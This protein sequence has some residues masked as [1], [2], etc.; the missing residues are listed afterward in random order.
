MTLFSC[1]LLGDETLTMGCGDQL[2]EQG[3]TIRAISTRDSS[4]R[5]WAKARGIAVL[6][7]FDDIR[8]EIAP[9]SID[10]VLSIANLRVIPDAVLAL[11]ARGAVNFHDGPL[12]EY[13]GLNTPVWALLNGEARHGITWHHV[14]AGVDEGDIMLQRRFDLAPD[15]TAH[16]LNARCY[17]AAMDS[18]PEVIRE[19][20]SA[21]PAR[22]PQDLSQR[23][24][25][26]MADLPEMAGL[27]DLRSMTTDRVLRHVRALDF[28]GYA[29]P[30]VT[31]KI[32]SATRRYA[33]RGA[34]PMQGRGA[35]G[36]ILRISGDTLSVATLD[37]AVHLSGI[38]TPDG[39]AAHLSRDLE[40]GEILRTPPAPEADRL[41]T[42]LR[43]S[44]R[45]EGHW[46]A[47][48]AD[49]QPA[50]VP[51]A[52]R[53]TT[54]DWTR[55]RINVDPGLDSG[56]RMAAVALWAL[57]S[58]GQ[59]RAAL[60]ARAQG[61]DDLICD[62][63]PVQAVP[64]ERFEDFT[65]SVAAQ[66]Q[67]GEQHLSFA[68]D[69]FARDPA[70]DAAH[71]PQI[72]VSDTDAPMADTA[73]T[74]CPGTGGEL[75]LHF[76][77]ARLTE[78][79]IGLLSA[80]LAAILTRLAAGTGSLR[81]LREIPAA[82]V[83]L[84]E[85]WNRT[86]TDY[87]ADL[88]LHGAFEAQVA[89]TPDDIALVFEDQ[90]LSYAALNSRANA[91]AQRLIAAGVGPGVNVGLCVRRS[92]DMMVAALG[93]LKAGGA[94]VP[95]DPAYP[96]GRIAHCV[97]DSAAT[98]IV[99]QRALHDLLP[100]S[101]ALL[102]DVEDCD[103]P[104]AQNPDKGV[105][106]DDLAYL[107][108]T[109]GTT[110]L[111]KGVMIAHRNLANFFAGMDA[112]IDRTTGNVWLAV[113]SLAFDISVLELF[114]TLARGFK[115]VIAG[116][117]NRAAVAGAGAGAMARA[118]AGAG[119]AMARSRRDIDFGIYYWGNDGGAGTQKYHL[120]LEGAKFADQNGFNAIWTPERHF[121]AF[122]G[123]YPNPAVTGAAVAAVTQNIGVRA[124]SCV[125][126]LHHPA[127]IA[128]EWA[129]IDN[130]TNGRAGLAI[131][132]GWQPDDFVLRPENAPPDNK[133]AMYDTLAQVRALWRGEAVA[134]P[135]A[136]G[137]THDVITQP[138]PVTP[139][140]PVWITTAGNPD[141][142]REAGELGCNVLTHLL[143]QSI[144]EVAGK[145]RIYHDA[146]RA[147][148]HDPQ[149]FKVTMML[150]TFIAADRD[151]AQRIAREPMKDY[152]RSAAGLIKQY[153]WTFP[154]FKRPEGVK[155]AYEMDLGI[156]G[157]DEL[158]AILDFAFER[159]F[160]E[161]GLFGTVEDGVARAEQLKR[162][163]VDEI[164]CLIDYGIDAQTVLDGLIPLAEVLKRA[165]APVT[166]AADDHSI[167]A[168]IIRHRVTHLQCTPSMARLIAMN[169][170]ARMALS[171]V[172]QILLGGE[173]LPGSLM[174]D[175]REATQA[176]VLNMYG[177]TETTIWSSV[178]SASPC[179]GTVPI[180][181]P[182]AN[183]SL[184]V[185]GADG[186]VS[187]IGVPGE[188]LIGGDG[189][190]PGYWQRADLT[191][192][193]FASGLYRTGDLVAWQADGSLRF[194][195]RSD[196]QVKIR[197]HRIELGEIETCLKGFAGV[198]EAVVIARAARSGD[199]AL[200]AYYT[201][202][203][204]VAEAALRDHLRRALPEVMVPSD[205]VLL[206]SFPLTPNKK[207]DR[208]ALPDPRAMRAPLAAN[209]SAAPAQGAGKVIA[210]VWC[211]IL[212]LPVVQVSDNFFDL[213]GHSLLAVQAHRDIR[214]KLDGVA[215]SITD[216]FRF[217]VLGDLAAHLD[218]QAGVS[219]TVAPRA[220]AP[221]RAA[222]M[223]KR[224][225]M[226][227]GRGTGQ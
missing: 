168:Q 72:G 148:G 179:A 58:S 158:E 33:V 40:I 197:G 188:L 23:R 126:P 37:G 142:W 32:A 224:R 13:A 69:L 103:T 75:G 155:S 108:Y 64:A 136:S 11:P 79:Q 6:P 180:G 73:I 163:G 65:R 217:P 176:Q 222:T 47:A 120:L 134:F 87:D 214:A 200:A 88:T 192:E 220:S 50:E 111:P 185:I 5:A 95:L 154:A 115:V 77:A 150:H 212:G 216:I 99:T 124:G 167:A 178:G 135:T 190:A 201:A 194:I 15:E 196:D 110:G 198:G 67:A 36:S 97:A 38:T 102:I 14:G 60:A 46:R 25:Y 80:R 191:A 119:G 182:I 81:E 161:S 78:A 62:W 166:L 19:L 164:A 105:G 17:G 118:G 114:Y 22:L 8:R 122:G 218:A 149:A 193:R 205:L 9:A 71:R 86:P 204:P 208:L 195:G 24:V 127:R 100:Q 4:V 21:A 159:Y 84:I 187:P 116:D 27:M 210:A 213:G 145:I 132:S 12:P 1:I 152:L 85:G 35:A 74:V 202:T 170:E 215:L 203:A 157:E 165:K 39:R 44:A 146:L 66:V 91:M 156:L 139:E 175:L 10:W 76:D 219:T 174:R 125:A 109:S 147:A 51:L 162:I 177:P 48:L 225:A 207:I 169:D 107:I 101:G 52:T 184:Q 59:E 55:R 117:E 26:R 83:D 226:R 70:L 112:H 61:L 56:A 7:G 104:V 89:R 92:L 129:V 93:I 172:R 151:T 130:L 160:E 29:N 153:A 3:A 133:T 209:L 171:G 41:D 94:Y 96:A 173:A 186:A 82:E 98:V 211:E 113:T 16:S 223:S 123:P 227:A 221:D 199:M 53:A 63:V 121:H 137:G 18:F 141:T 128:E 28:A 30:V 206:E 181:G 31:A 144:D 189:V 34:S 138:R 45:H 54:P 57:Q 131:A 140:L 49:M 42:T 20:A 90:S 183:T 143:G 2:I 68:C 106:P 43:E